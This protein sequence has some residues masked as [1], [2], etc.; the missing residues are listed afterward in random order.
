MTPARPFERRSLGDQRTCLVGS[1]STLSAFLRWNLFQ[2]LEY[3]GP[4]R[5]G[6]RGTNRI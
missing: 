3:V 6:R 5:Y 2:L 4:D 1:A